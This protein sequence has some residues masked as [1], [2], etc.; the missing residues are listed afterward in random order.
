MASV[1]LVITGKDEASPVF[2]SVQTS[3]EKTTGS[4]SALKSAAETAAA[5]FG[6][7]KLAQFAEQASMMAARSETLAVVMKVV[8]QN[9]GY[10][11]DQMAGYAQGVANMGITVEESRC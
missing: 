3:V 8:G 10:T 6:A 4:L 5:A 2:K 9:A 11:A 7:Y 1:S